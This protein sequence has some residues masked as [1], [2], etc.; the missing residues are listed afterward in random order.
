[1]EVAMRTPGSVFGGAAGRT[2]GSTFGKTPRASGVGGAAAGAGAGA[3]TP[4]GAAG[5]HLSMYDAPPQG[6]VALEEFERFALDRLRVLRGLEDARA[7]GKKGAEVD[8]LCRTLVAKHL[9]VA[10]NAEATARKDVVSHFV[11][12]LTYCRTE[13]LR[14]WLIQQECVLFRARF[15]ML[16][17]QEQVRFL[18]ANG[19]PYAPLGAAEFAEVRDALAGVAKSLD[20][21]AE[22]SA[23]RAS[24]Y[25][26]VP[27]EQVPELVMRRA[28]LVRRGHAYVPRDQLAALVVGQFRARLSKALVQTARQWASV[29]APGE[30]ERLGPLVEALARRGAADGAAS[31]GATAREGAVSLADLP[32]VAAQSMPLCMRT[33]YDELKAKHHLKHAGRMQLGLYLKGLG[34]SLDDALAFWRGEFTKG[35]P[36]ERFDKEYAYNVRHNYGKEGKRT[37]YTP[38]SCMKIIGNGGCPYRAFEDDS[39]A[40]ALNGMGLAPAAQKEARAFAKGHHYQLAC[41]C[42]FEALHDASEVAINHPNE[43]TKLSL[44]AIAEKTAPKTPA[45]EKRR[46]PATD[47][48]VTPV[49]P[50]ETN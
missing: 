20:A 36:A 44:A 33:L 42:T 10:G 18:G 45:A 49:T 25:Y 30:A 21:R 9:R 27:F 19:L 37:D 26:S 2:P 41:S 12:R 13:E 5:G 31:G 24:D 38:Y 47:G 23:A 46:A 6:D 29:V 14:R 1:M 8:E 15:K 3:A 48:S 43:Y 35:M 28:V 34:L 16:P 40:A 22:T 50:M 39:L 4:G 11:A 7:R 17:A 32:Q